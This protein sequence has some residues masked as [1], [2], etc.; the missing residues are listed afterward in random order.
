MM[1]PTLNRFEMNDFVERL[2]ARE[3]AAW[4]DLYDRHVREI[5]GYVFH[6]VGR[7]SSVAEEVVQETWMNALQGIARFDS[8]TNQMRGWLFAIARSQVALHYRRLRVVVGV[9]SELEAE[10]AELPDMPIDELQQL[11][12]ID[13]VRAALIELP[14]AYRELLLEKYVDRKS[15]RELASLRGKTEKA[16]EGLLTRARAE[17]RSLLGWYFSKHGDVDP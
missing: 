15:V 14:N 5:Y 8:A 11:E 10:A 3:S 17:L 6:L 9:P 2:K 4:V 13:V 7:N 1:L 12:L 16:I